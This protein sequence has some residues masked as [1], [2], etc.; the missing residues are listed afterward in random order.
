MKGFLISTPRERLI[1]VALAVAGYV[2]AAF[3]FD[4]LGGLEGY[5][6]VD[7]FL[8]FAPGLAMSL[9][10]VRPLVNG[11]FARGSRWDVARFWAGW[12][13]FGHF[14]AMIWAVL[15]DWVLAGLPPLLWSGAEG[16]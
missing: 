4:A 11:T 14:A 10:P 1:A 5:G 12:T 13:L 9:K 2:W 6:G 7:L 15:D 16:A 3:C 8:V